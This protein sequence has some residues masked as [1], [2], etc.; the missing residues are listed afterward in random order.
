ML[1]WLSVLV[2]AVGEPDALQTLELLVTPQAVDPDTAALTYQPYDLPGCPT[3][4][5]PWRRIIDLHDA[6]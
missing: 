5:V 6:W 4:T 2:L 3:V 1:S